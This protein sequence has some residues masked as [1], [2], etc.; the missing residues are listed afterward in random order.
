MKFVSVNE[1]QNRA[2]QII[3]DLSKEDVIVTRSGHPTAALIHL[4]EEDV[5]SF[6]MAHHPTLM[7]ELDDSY[8]GY[9]A[10]GGISHSEM[11]TKLQ[12]T[13]NAG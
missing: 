6:L 3:E 12:Q 4:G 7:Q 8:S 5:E 9:Q 2:A 10:S 1:L 11:K 13:R